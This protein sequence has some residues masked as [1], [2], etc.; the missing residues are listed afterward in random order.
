M[1]L[2]EVFGRLDEERIPSGSRPCLTA[3]DNFIVA[4]IPVHTAPLIEHVKPTFAL[5][6]SL[7]HHPMSVLLC[8]LQLIDVWG[9][10]FSILL[11]N[12]ST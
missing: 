11:N 7:A 5:D 8:G 10:V 4:T 6:L 2:T 3:S 12:I 9:K 1:L